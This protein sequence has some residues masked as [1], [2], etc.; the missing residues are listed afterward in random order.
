MYKIDPERLYDGIDRDYAENPEVVLPEKWQFLK[1][2][3]VLKRDKEWYDAAPVFRQP[4]QIAAF[5]V[6]I[7]QGIEDSDRE[8]MYTI[9][10][11][12]FHRV[13]GVHEVHVGT[14][15]ESV[16]HPRELYKA[17]ILAGAKAIA[18]I[19]NHPSGQLKFSKN[20]LAILRRLEVVS[21]IVGIKILDFLIIG[22]RGEFLA[23][24][25]QGILRDEKTLVRDTQGII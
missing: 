22:H 24:S 7:L 19:H 11:D 20:D 5:V 14:L 8:R 23:A 16:A 17:A 2:E 1:V 10:V 15:D 21:L 3:T 13:V 18:F 4:D 9:F 25:Q 12:N 6:A